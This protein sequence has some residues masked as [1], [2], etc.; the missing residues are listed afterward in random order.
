MRDSRNEQLKKAPT[1]AGLANAQAHV[2]DAASKKLGG[3]AKAVGNDEV[4]QRLQQG[5][6]ARDALLQHAVSRLGAIREAQ[7]RE[8]DLTKG[9][10]TRDW[11]KEVSDQ[12][13]GIGKPEPTR[14]T[15]AARLYEQASTMICSGHL[16]RGAELM[17][18]AEAEESQQMDRVTSLIDVRDLQ[19]DVD[20]GAV[21]PDLSAGAA[22][23]TCPAPDGL[24]VATEIQQV[25]ET[26]ADPAVM[27]RTTD[28]WW[29]EE[30]EE[31]E[32]VKPVS[33]ANS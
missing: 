8:L 22:C 9:T 18:R 26:V 29:T 5:A 23:P 13:K 31:E 21:A 28:P 11:W 1:T 25:S 27:K 17:K 7:V 16:A 2:G 32:E 30:E 24:E 15:E 3:L 20:S 6:T 33:N 10:N 14:W 12:Q 4:Q 19:A